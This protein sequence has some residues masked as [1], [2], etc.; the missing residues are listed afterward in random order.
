MKPAVFPENVYSQQK[1]NR[2]IPIKIKSK[3]IKLQS[4]DGE[5]AGEV[6]NITSAPCTSAPQ[7]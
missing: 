6:Y 1:E 4:V 7:Q 3:E 2:T 5:V